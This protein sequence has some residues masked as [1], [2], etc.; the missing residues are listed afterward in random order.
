MSERTAMN[1]ARPNISMSMS[2]RLKSFWALS[3]S[4]RKLKPVAL[5]VIAFSVLL[6]KR[7]Q[8]NFGYSYG[9]DFPAIFNFGDSNS[10]TGGKS[11]AFDRIPYPNGETFFHK[12]SGRYCN[13]KL[14]LDFI[15]R[16][17]LLKF[18]SFKHWLCYIRKM[19][20]TSLGHIFLFFN[21]NLGLF[22]AEK[23]K[24]PYLNAYLDSIGTNF[25]HG[26]N[27]AIGGSTI[28]PL[29]TRV[30]NQGFNPISLD[31]QILQ[32]EQLRERTNELYKE[33]VNSNIRSELPRPEDFT[34][35]LYTFDIGQNDLDAAFNFM[36][37]EQ[38][39]ASVPGLIDQLAHAVMVTELLVYCFSPFLRWGYLAT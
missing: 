15:G 13:G 32:F 24:L 1:G 8:N 5:F 9:C 7:R 12:Q 39:L 18:S 23:L 25:R 14:V 21:I 33:G 28:Q 30:F 4:I 6:L 10:D 2:M 17:A 37:E 16:V 38:V 22:A 34:K 36:T 20:I 31:I 26:A 19:K 35:A 11:A 29:D 27:F 3:R